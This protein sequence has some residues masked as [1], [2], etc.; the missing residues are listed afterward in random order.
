V[1][2][3]MPVVFTMIVMRELR[4]PSV[5]EFEQI[6]LN[7]MLVGSIAPLVVLAIATVAFGN[8]VDD[9]TLA[10]LTLTPIPRWKI[11]LAKLLATISVAVPFMA[12]SALVTT[13]VAFNADTTATIAV[14]IGSVVGVALYSSAFVWLGLATTQAIGV[15]LLYIVLWEGFFSGYISGV[16]LFSLHHYAIAMMHGLDER[17]FAEAQ[18][19]SLG[20]AVGVSVV[21]IVGFLLLTIRRLRRMDVP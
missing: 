15:G 4:V 12:I 7:G 3:A 5:E 21:V 6:V 13:H 10:N 20:A 19:V 14:T 17:R 18:T 2:A 16:R 8:E 11:A 9:R 1:L